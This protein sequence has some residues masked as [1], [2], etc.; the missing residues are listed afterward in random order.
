MMRIMRSRLLSVVVGFM[1]IAMS[2]V[3]AMADDSKVYDGRLEG[4]GKG[5]TLEIGGTSLTWL[6]LV[7]VGILGLGVM[8]K[9][10]KRSHLD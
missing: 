7:G 8:F 4:Y 1:A 5:V 10:A 6:L 3:L 9:N 2:P